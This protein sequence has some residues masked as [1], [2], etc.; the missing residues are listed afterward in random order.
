M[1]YP[2]GSHG[3][4]DLHMSRGGV[5]VKH[6]LNN[7][8]RDTR[9]LERGLDVSKAEMIIT[10]GPIYSNTSQC[11]LKDIGF[12][13]FKSEEQT[14]MFR[15]FHGA[16]VSRDQERYPALPQP[17]AQTSGAQASPQSV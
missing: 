14:L 8:L 1:R 7:P 4:V 15:S 13:N 6:G 17:C 11:G 2:R 9:S 10:F 12:F 3:P 16:I 5:H